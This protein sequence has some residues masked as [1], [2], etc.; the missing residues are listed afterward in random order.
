MAA[1]LQTLAWL[2]AALLFIAVVLGGLGFVTAAM[3]R[4]TA[5]RGEA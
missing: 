2:A 1:F 4:R 3:D 5:D